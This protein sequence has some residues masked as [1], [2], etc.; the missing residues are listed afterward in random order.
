MYKP[1]SQNPVL[2][3]KDE[4]IEIWSKLFSFWTFYPDIFLDTMRPK[5]PETGELMGISLDFS[6]RIFLRSL[7]RFEQTYHCY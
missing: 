7:F 6:Q 3:S 5:D 1:N 2:L 4:Q